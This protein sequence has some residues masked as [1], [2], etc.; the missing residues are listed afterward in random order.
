MQ[1]AANSLGSVQGLPQRH[2]LGHLANRR[3]FAKRM[4]AE[5]GVRNFEDFSGEK[6]RQRLAAPQRSLLARNSHGIGLV[7]LTYPPFHAVRWRISLPSMTRHMQ[8]DLTDGNPA[9]EVKRGYSADSNETL[10][11]WWCA[12]GVLQQRRLIF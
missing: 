11:E 9:S 10:S 4:Q 6:P 1:Y 8:A 2:T 3:P 7:G 5:R 12:V